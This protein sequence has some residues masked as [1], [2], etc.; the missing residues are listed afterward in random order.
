MRSDSVMINIFRESYQMRLSLLGAT[1]LVALACGT[2]A[3]AQLLPPSNPVVDP[4]ENPQSRSDD[5]LC[6]RSFAWSIVDLRQ[7]PCPCP[8]VRALSWLE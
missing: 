2:R 5:Q 6:Q 8:R 1:T 4:N 7:F 3:H